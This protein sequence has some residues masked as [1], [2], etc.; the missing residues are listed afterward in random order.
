MKWVYKTN[1]EL[2]VHDIFDSLVYIIYI[3]WAWK[4][5]YRFFRAT[6]TKIRR[7]KMNHIWTQKG[8]SS[9]HE[10]H[11]KKKNQRVAI[12][13]KEKNA[14]KLQKV[15]FQKS[16]NCSLRTSTKGRLL[17]TFNRYSFSFKGGLCNRRTVLAIVRTKLCAREASSFW[18]FWKVTSCDFTLVYSF[19]T[20]SNVWFLRCAW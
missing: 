16:Q 3:H 7:I 12:V 5:T 10:A 20:H 18:D 17:R 9:P 6:L 4:E 11:L 19:L 14:V 13:K 1:G 2:W 8:Y 15:I